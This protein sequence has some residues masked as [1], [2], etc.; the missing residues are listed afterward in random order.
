[1]YCPELTTK[2]LIVKD[3]ITNN[4]VSSS[5]ELEFALQCIAECECAKSKESFDNMLDEAENAISMYMKSFAECNIELLSLKEEINRTRALGDL[6]KFDLKFKIYCPGRTINE[7]ERVYRDVVISKN[8][9]VSVSSYFNYGLYDKELEY[10]EEIVRNLEL[11]KSE[12]YQR[13]VVGRFKD[14]KGFIEFFSEFLG[15]KCYCLEKCTEEEFVAKTATM[16]S[17][18]LKPVNEINGKGI[19]VIDLENMTPNK[20]AE[21]MG[22]IKNKCYILEER[23]KQHG[24][25]ESLHPESINTMRIVTTLFD[26]EPIIT[27]GTLKMGTGKSQIDNFSTGGLIVRVGDEGYCDPVAYDHTGKEY[28]AHPD[29]GIVFQGVKI[30]CWEDVRNT[31]KAAARKA[32]PAIFVGWDVAVGNDGRVFII[33]AECLC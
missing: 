7:K 14:K 29:S 25:I 21:V 33:E 17:V 18:I 6:C 32:A 28:T 15:R 12:H 4:E 1:M 20:K 8:E 5:K 30:P 24:R 26:G 2:A 22:V 10:K 27:S 19:M 16:K 3:K 23:I 11:V 31:V 9:G 13:D